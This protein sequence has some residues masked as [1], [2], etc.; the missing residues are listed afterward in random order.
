MGTLYQENKIAPNTF[1]KR[2]QDLSITESLDIDLSEAAS[3]AFANL[4]G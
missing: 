4:F 3:V 2:R 1:H